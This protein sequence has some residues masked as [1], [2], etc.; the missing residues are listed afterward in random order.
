M[1]FSANLNILLVTGS[2]NSL[3]PIKNKTVGTWFPI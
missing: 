1:N 2:S 3:M